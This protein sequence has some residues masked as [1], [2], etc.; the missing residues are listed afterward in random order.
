M[1]ELKPGLEQSPGKT[2]LDEP[3]NLAELLACVDRDL[4]FRERWI[5][6]HPGKMMPQAA[7]RELEH[8][9][10]VRARL[11]RSAA[12]YIVALQLA[13]AAGVDDDA[14][15]RML[16]KAEALVHDLYPKLN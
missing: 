15:G 12:L 2:A 13:V 16:A 11:V 14:V 6:R 5:S 4:E 3:A 8:M 9:R 1:R 10:A 7:Q